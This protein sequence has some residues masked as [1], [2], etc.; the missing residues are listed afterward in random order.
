VFLTH[1]SVPQPWQPCDDDAERSLIENCCLKE[2]TQPWELRHPP[3]TTDRAVRVP[4]V[5]TLLLFAL[6]TA[7]RL[8]CA[9]ADSAGAEPVGWPR[10]RRLRLEQTRHQVIVLAQGDSGLV[11]LAESSLL[12]GV[13]LTDRPPGIGT[14][15]PILAKSRLTTDG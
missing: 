12:L 7:Y 13:N 15:Q 11:H 6:A 8:P 9:Q 4:V 2:A 3:Q 14:R 5:C 10:W 1:A